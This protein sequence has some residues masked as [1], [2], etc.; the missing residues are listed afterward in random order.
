DAAG[1]ADELSTLPGVHL[2][3][4]DF[5]PA[6]DV[7]Q[8]HGV[9][10]LRRRVRAADHFGADFQAVGGEDVAL[11]AVGVLNQGDVARAVGVV[12]DRLDRRLDAV[13]VAFEIDQA[14]EAL[15]PTAAVLGGD[16]AV[17]V[18]PGG[19]ALP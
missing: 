11:L 8:R 2:D 3:V 17:V 9:A 7:G 16:H 4:V 14:V 10:K 1:A 19:A 18:A 12:L 6:R 5:Q 13:L 15:V